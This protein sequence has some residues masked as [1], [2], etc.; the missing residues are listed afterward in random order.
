MVMFYL[1]GRSLKGTLN[2]EMSNECEQDIILPVRFT[3]LK[4]FLQVFETNSLVERIHFLMWS[5]IFCLAGGIGVELFF[6][7]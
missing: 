5:S 6:F 7:F 2:L 4:G 1:S 3:S